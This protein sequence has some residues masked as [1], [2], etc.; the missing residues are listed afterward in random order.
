MKKIKMYDGGDKKFLAL[1]EKAG[2]PAT[3]RQYKKFMKK[4]GKAFRAQ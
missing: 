4:F 2:T 1:C 3:R